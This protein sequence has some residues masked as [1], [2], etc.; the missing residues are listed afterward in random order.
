[1][2]SLSSTTALALFAMS[3]SAAFCSALAAMS[4]RVASRIQNLLSNRMMFSATI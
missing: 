2:R 1:M 4:L 3:R